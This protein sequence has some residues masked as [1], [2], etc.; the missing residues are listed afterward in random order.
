MA[1]QNEFANEDH[2]RE[3]LLMMGELDLREREGERYEDNNKVMRPIVLSFR[4]FN[5]ARVCSFPR[6]LIPTHLLKEQSLR[7]EHRI[8]KAHIAEKI[9]LRTR[10][11]VRK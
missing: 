10:K 7:C 2:V 5:H 3:Q 6:L 11:K 8:R 9:T 4:D 1:W